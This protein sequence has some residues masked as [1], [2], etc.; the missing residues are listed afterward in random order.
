MNFNNVIEANI[1]NN[2]I[3]EINNN[4]VVIVNKSI[5]F[6]FNMINIITISFLIYNIII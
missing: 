1:Q 6:K 3:I 5:Y 4:N 2:V